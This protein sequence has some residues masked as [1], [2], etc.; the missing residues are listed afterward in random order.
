M[1]VALL[2]R[3]H[4]EGEKKE[5]RLCDTPKREGRCDVSL[6]TDRVGTSRSLTLCSFC[7]VSTSRCF[8]VKT[9]RMV[10]E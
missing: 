9:N 6:V 3:G 2:G 10:S 5:D 8:S 1:E 7:C 4:G